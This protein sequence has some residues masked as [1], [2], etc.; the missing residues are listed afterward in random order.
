MGRRGEGGTEVGE[1]RERR[2]RR[3]ETRR[4]RE[5]KAV[6]NRRLSEGICGIS[7]SPGEVMEG[8]RGR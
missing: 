8:E 1:R 4:E 7:G 3:C 2:E 5:D 6:E